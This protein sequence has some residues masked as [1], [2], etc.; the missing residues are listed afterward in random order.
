MAPINTKWPRSFMIRVRKLGFK[1][2][3]GIWFTQYCINLPCM[4]A[5]G[6]GPWSVLDCYFSWTNLGHVTIYELIHF[7]KMVR[8]WKTKSPLFCLRYD[9]LIVF[10]K[11]KSYNFHFHKNDVTWPLSANGLLSVNPSWVKWSIFK[12]SQTSHSLERA[13]EVKFFPQWSGEGQIS[14]MSMSNL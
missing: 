14:V 8:V 5:H 1:F 6:T 10:L 9:P 7:K 3:T 12:T 13:Q 11:V 2:W 4:E